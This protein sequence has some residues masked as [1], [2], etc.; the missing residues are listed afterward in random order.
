MS[1]VPFSVN[2]WGS[3]PAEEN[4][5]CWMGI[6]FDSLETARRVFADPSVLDTE[7][8]VFDP[9]NLGLYRGFLKEMGSRSTIF[10][11]LCRNTRHNNDTDCET[12]ESRRLRPD[13][14]KRRDDSWRREVAREE[15][16][17]HGVSAYNEVMGWD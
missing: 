16:M 12:L 3:D 14:P 11:E 17:L 15:G 13:Q 1:A 5:D 9:L 10:I 4:D 8:S 6:D 7:R 2:L